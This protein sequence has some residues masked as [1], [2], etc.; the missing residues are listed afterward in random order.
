MYESV[1]AGVTYQPDLLSSSGSEPFVSQGGPPQVKGKSFG[2]APPLRPAAPLGAEPFKPQVLGA[3]RAGRGQG[4]KGQG[5]QR[6]LEE[7]LA[8]KVGGIGIFPPTETDAFQHTR[9]P[10]SAAPPET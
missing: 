6:G 10:Q 9:L 1:A 5:G 3:W 4:W 2:M 8:P 7:L